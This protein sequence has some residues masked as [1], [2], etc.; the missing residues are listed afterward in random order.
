MNLEARS[1]AAR[2]CFEGSESRD[3][4]SELVAW[5]VSFCECELVLEL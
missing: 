4:L 5:P 1:R 3:R 2:Q